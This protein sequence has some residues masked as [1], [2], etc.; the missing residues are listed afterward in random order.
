[1]RTPSLTALSVPAWL[2][3]CNNGEA[4]ESNSRCTLMPWRPQGNL[5][6]SGI[7]KQHMELE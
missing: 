1:M 2:K 6:R 3:G 7:M 4:G 5:V